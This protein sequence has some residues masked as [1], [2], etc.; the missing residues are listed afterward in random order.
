[1]NNDSYRSSFESAVRHKEAGPA[2]MEHVVGNVFKTRFYPVKANGRRTARVVY[3]SHTRKGKVQFL[4]HCQQEV[5]PLFSFNASVDAPHSIDKPRLSG[6]N[7]YLGTVDFKA[8]EHRK[9]QYI[10]D[11]GMVKDA[12]LRQHFVV[13][14]PGTH[15]FECLTNL[16]LLLE[17]KDNLYI[18]CEMHETLGSYF[19]IKDV[20]EPPKTSRPIPQTVTIGILWVGF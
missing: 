8:N 12:S 4:L 20:I 2:M 5:I 3:S 1:M 7:D 10:I 16:Q 11:T 19:C 14:V 13:E 9:G 6:K 15:S 17:P 18:L